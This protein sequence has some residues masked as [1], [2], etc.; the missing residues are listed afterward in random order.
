MSV[1]SAPDGAVGRWWA[2]PGAFLQLLYKLFRQF[3][4]LNLTH[5]CQ[6]L[7]VRIHSPWLTQSPKK[8]LVRI[9]LK[10]CHSLSFLFGGVG[11]PS[12][13]SPDPLF[14]QQTSECWSTPWVVA[15]MNRRVLFPPMLP[16]VGMDIHRGEGLLIAGACSQHQ[17]AVCQKGIV[18]SL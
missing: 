8:G 9:H 14:I 10:S 11:G 12:A 16:R 3:F 18:C 13:T 4:E 17:R 2:R 6:K 1:S 5:Y 7:P 15:G